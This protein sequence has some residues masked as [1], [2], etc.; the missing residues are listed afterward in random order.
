M[1]ELTNDPGHVGG[2][3]QQPPHP[4]RLLVSLNAPSRAGRSKLFMLPRRKGG[5]E[6]APLQRSI[7]PAASTPRPCPGRGSSWS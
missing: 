2:S 5:E 6:G 4:C 3:H 1:R 7:F